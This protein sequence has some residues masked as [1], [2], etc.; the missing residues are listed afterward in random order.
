[1]QGLGTSN[2]QTSNEGVVRGAAGIAEP[3]RCDSTDRG[4]YSLV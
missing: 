3:V 2:A 4:R 1:L